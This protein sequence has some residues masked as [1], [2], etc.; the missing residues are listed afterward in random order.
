MIHVFH[1]FNIFFIHIHPFPSVFLL[2]FPCMCLSILSSSLTSTPPISVIYLTRQVL[3]YICKLRISIKFLLGCRCL[4]TVCSLSFRI[5]GAQR[6]WLLPKLSQYVS[7]GII[8]QIKFS[9]L[10]AYEYTDQL[11]RSLICILAEL[12][13]WYWHKWTNF[14]LWRLYIIENEN[15]SCLSMFF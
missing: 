4:L 6:S 13:S 8:N 15:I 1:F 12:F 2:Y 14:T 3:R 5:L 11:N 7:D 10:H 9:F